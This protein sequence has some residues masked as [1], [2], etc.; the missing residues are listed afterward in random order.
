MGDQQRI[1]MVQREVGTGGLTACAEDALEVFGRD[2]TGQRANARGLA[3]LRPALPV[4]LR[5]RG[6]CAPWRAGR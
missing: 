6:A 5:R 3:P 4:S 2:E 1:Q